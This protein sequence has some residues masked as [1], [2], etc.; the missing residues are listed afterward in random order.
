MS[1]PAR[2]AVT[3]EAQWSR[4]RGLRTSPAGG[5]EP[6]GAPASS[7]SL[8]VA[9]TSSLR[10]PVA[11]YRNKRAPP[12]ID[13]QIVTGWNGLSFSAFDLAGFTLAGPPDTK[14]AVL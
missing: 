2:P 13:R 10:V 4:R 14:F 6:P 8:C 3:A 7:A 5:E 11:R 1:P 9:A 12:P